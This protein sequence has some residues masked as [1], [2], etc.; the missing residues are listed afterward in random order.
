MATAPR[1]QIPLKLEFLGR[2]NKL[3]QPWAFYLQTLD[4]NLPPIGGSGFV[5]DGTAGTTGVSTIYQGLA[6]N[7][8]SFP[9]TNDIYLAT[10][11]GQIFTVQAGNWQEQLPQITGDATKPAFSHVI[12]FNTI[13]AT[14]GTFGDGSNIPVVSVNEKGLITGVTSVPVLAPPVIVPGSFGDTIFKGLTSTG[15]ETFEHLNKDT[16]T[17]TYTF[18]YH[19]DDATPAVLFELPL[20]RRV[21]RAIINVET[22]FDDVASTLSLGSLA[23]P[24]DILDAASVGP[25]LIGAFEAQPN[26][27]YLVNTDVYLFINPGTSTQGSGF[28]SITLSS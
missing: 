28:V 14:P 7:R 12:T 13:N 23:A 25:N 22:V 10:D 16:F 17:V 1:T 20:N 24:E 2:D 9:S 5:V 21:I 19:F 18:E 3:S 26:T 4:A 6:A 11:T 27:Q 15:F 8:G